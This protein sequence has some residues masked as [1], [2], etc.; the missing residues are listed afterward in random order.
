MARPLSAL[1]AIALLA[2]CN[3]A[4][5]PAQAPERDTA[6]PPP[7]DA[8][9]VTTDPATRWDLQ[10]SGEGTA[11]VYPAS[12]DPRIRL[13][14]PS[15]TRELLVNVPAFRPVGSEERLSLGSGGAVEALVADPRG[16]RARGGVSAT[17][18]VPANLGALLGGP[19][20]ASYGAQASGPHPEPPDALVRA[21][22]AGCGYPPPP[23]PP[24]PSADVPPG[25]V[26][27]CLLQDGERLA[28]APLRAIGT[29]PFWG[30]QIE[31]RCVTY[32]HP[33]NQHGT[34]VWTRYT[35]S[36][37]G[38]TWTGALDGRPFVLRTRP[39]PGCSDGMSDRRYPIAV[40]LTVGGE[41]RQGCAEAW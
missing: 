33:D 6:V 27:A 24:P 23:P 8:A 39:R 4:E 18:A 21:F 22:L 13:F 32:S 17:G 36:A 38:G 34:R 5:D 40:E 16:D 29:E 9:P 35:A 31:G 28:V 10:A 12:G 3:A 15:G 37:G 11:L 14:C 20:S 7:S 26:G 2:S 1:A 30:A 25:R 41:E 19:V